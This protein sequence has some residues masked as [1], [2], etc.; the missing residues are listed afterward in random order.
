MSRLTHC[1]LVAFLT[2][3]SP[4]AS[5]FPDHPVSQ[6]LKKLQCAVYNRLYPIIS[7]H[8][9]DSKTGLGCPSLSLDTNGLLAPGSRRLRAS[10]SLYCM[11]TLPEPVRLNQESSPAGF[12]TPLPHPGPLDKETEGSSTGS[13][14]P[15]VDVTPSLLDKDS[16]FEDLEH[17]LAAPDTWARGPGG[18][19]GSQTPGK[20][21]VTLPVEAGIKE[22]MEDAVKEG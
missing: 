14:S 21:P 22:G 8:A 5:S 10:Q 20:K 7:K 11:F 6:L 1:F 2:S 9:A 16:S 3:C 12:P 13:P 15:L 17:L 18:L 19:P 4:L